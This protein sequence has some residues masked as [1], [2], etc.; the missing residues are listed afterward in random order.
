MFV[1]SLF[2][3]YPPLNSQLYFS[4]SRFTVKEDMV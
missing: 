2:V 4:N 3:F 1:L